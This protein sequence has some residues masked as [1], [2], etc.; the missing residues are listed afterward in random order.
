MNFPV[1]LYRAGLTPEVEAIRTFFHN[2]AIRFTEIDVREDK[3]AQ[4]N[5][6]RWT[7]GQ[8]DVF[9]LVR[10][11]EKILALF[12]QPAPDVLSRMFERGSLIEDS[13]I[14]RLPITVFSAGWCPDCRFLESYLQRAGKTFAKVDI[15][16]TPGAPEKIIQW[17][18]GRRVIPTVRVGEKIIFFNPG[19]QIFGNFLAVR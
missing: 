8:N 19:T 3:N 4:A 6:E 18:G 17:S 15:E 7:E 10:V 13:E 12:L 5:V 2:Q 14:D 1:Y 9:P 16:S 11:G